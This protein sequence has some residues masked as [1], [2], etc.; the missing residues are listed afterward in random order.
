MITARIPKLLFK[1]IYFFFF[2]AYKNEQGEHK[3][4]RQKKQKSEFYKSKKLTS[5]GDVNVNKI[6]VSKK[7]SYGTKNSFKY[8]IGYSDNDVST[9]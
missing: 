8:F 9:P 5:M 1:K 4:W 2:T 7:E 6:L 3:F